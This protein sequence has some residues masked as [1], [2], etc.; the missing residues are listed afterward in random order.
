MSLRLTT[1]TI[2]NPQVARKVAI[3][4]IGWGCYHELEP[5][6]HDLW[7]VRVKPEMASRIQQWLIEEGVDPQTRLVELYV[8]F[9]EGRWETRLVRIPAA[10]PEPQIET[11]ATDFLIQQLTEAKI[12]AAFIGLYHTPE[13]PETRLVIVPSLLVDLERLLS[14]TEAAKNHLTPEQVQAWRDISAHVADRRLAV[15]GGDV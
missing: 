9:S 5:L 6:P 13:V 15:T 8:G 12:E 14:I 2:P 11:V 1:L 3:A 7:E 4:L 10:T